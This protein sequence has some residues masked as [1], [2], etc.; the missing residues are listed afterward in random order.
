MKLSIDEAA[1]ALHLQLVDSDVIESEEVAPG[2]IMDYD[3]NGE[4]VGIEI[5]HLSKRPHPVDVSD[6]QF[7]THRKPKDEKPDVPVVA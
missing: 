7:Q 5:L 3:N 6:F 2:V 4:V 1:D